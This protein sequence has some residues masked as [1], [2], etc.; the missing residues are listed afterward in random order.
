M[1]HS[2]RCSRIAPALAGALLLA[3]G[4]AWGQGPTQGHG[5]HQ[6][7]GQALTEALARLTPA[8]R[9][10]YVQALR[11]LEESRSRQRLLQLDAAQRCLAAADAAP[12]IRSCWQAFAQSNQQQRVQQ[13]QQLQ[14]LAQRFGLPQPRAGSGRRQGG[15]N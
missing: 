1:S 13:M 11:A 3:A 15:P 12:A 10:E 14:A 8:Q 4:S 2:S 9:V 7:H 5:G 6:G